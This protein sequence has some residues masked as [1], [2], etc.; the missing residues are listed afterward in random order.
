MGA[1]GKWGQNGQNYFYIS[2]AVASFFRGRPR[3]R[4][5]KSSF[6]RRLSPSTQPVAPNGKLRSTLWRIAAN[7]MLS[8]AC[9]T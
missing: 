4:M 3:A 7:S 6:R 5:V 2:P 9:C 1:H 8:Q